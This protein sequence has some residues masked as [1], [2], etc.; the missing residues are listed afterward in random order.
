[1]LS[2]SDTENTIPEGSLHSR[3]AHTSY[4][5][6]NPNIITVWDSGGGTSVQLITG[7]EAD[8]LTLMKHSRK[9]SAEEAGEDSEGLR[10]DGREAAF[11]PLPCASRE[12]L[13]HV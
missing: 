6:K 5:K 10:T 9:S 2:F 8:G 3:E 7:R 1:M 13:W 4:L 12:G 11:S